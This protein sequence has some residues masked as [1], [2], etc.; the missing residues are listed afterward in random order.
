MKF[1]TVTNGEA[2]RKFALN[3]AN[4][5]GRMEEP[6]KNVNDNSCLWAVVSK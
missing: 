3:L 5:R 2:S 6:P 1:Y 4:P